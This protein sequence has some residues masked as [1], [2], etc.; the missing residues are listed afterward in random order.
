VF[1]EVGHVLKVE[2]ERLR[3]TENYIYIYILD[4][5]SCSV[6]SLQAAQCAYSAVQVPTPA[7]QVHA[8]ECDSSQ[9]IIFLVFR[10]KK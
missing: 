8:Y 6:P 10:N 9:P 5:D 7:Q 4:C 3:L 2:E 1:L